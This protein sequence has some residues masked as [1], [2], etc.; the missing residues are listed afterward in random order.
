MKRVRLI[1]ATTVTQY[2]RR[3]A[4]GRI[5]FEDWLWKIKIA[6]WSDS[7]DVTKTYKGNLLGG[8]SDRVIFDLG[9][10]GRNAFRMICMY[11]FRI[12]NVNLYVCWI[13]THEEYNRLTPADKRTVTIR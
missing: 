1:K 12:K 2:A 13:G 10:D 8:G 9:G 4:N 6:R 3:H 11:S 5:Y 7:T